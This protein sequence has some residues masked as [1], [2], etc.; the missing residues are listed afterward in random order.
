LHDL[1][2]IRFARPDARSDDR[3][4]FA[5]HADGSDAIRSG[6]ASPLDS[7]GRATLE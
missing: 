2:R 6:S 4:R 5:D 7:T 1:D 3:C